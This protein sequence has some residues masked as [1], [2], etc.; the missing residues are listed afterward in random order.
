MAV[1]PESV[2]V[3][4][5]LRRSA[6]FVR[7]SGGSRYGGTRFLGR[8]G[9][10]HAACR[11]AALLAR[12]R[13]LTPE[14]RKREGSST[15]R[16]LLCGFVVCAVLAPP[17]YA[18][19]GSGGGGGGVSAPG[20]PRV[21]S[22]S[23]LA[24]PAGT[25]PGTKKLLRGRGFVVRGHGLATAKR[26]VFKGRRGRAD[27]VSIAPEQVT[28]RYATATV[29]QAARSG[30]V[31][32]LDRH[33]YFAAAPRRVAVSDAPAPTPVDLAPGSRF[34]FDGRRKPSF[35]FEVSSPVTAQV[36]LVNEASGAVVKTWEV[37]AA[38]GQPGTVSWDG[39][40]GGGVEDAGPYRFRLVGQAAAA[41]TGTPSGEAFFFAD[42]VFPI[43]GRHNLGYTRTNNF[44]GG[45]GHKGQDAFARCGTRVAAARGGRVQYAGYHSAAG[46]YAVIDGAETGIDYVYMHMLSPALVRTGQRVFTG[47]KIGEVGESGRATG[48]HLH[49]ELW[50]APGWYEGGQAFDPMPSLTLW[51]SYS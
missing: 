39:L 47:Q 36:E 27:D 32:V 13:Q 10:R 26:I 16:T 40:G 43:R 15:L 6:E 50:T 31:A 1:S 48:C 38:P 33:G 29:P 46:Y 41:T 49:F 2:L 11:S 5:T 23:C 37:P 18:E 20:A 25:C 9:R 44:G 28:G 7:R 4:P 12:V 19:D 21:D 24:T 35:S 30:G 3:S 34:F 14:A 8:I 42:H 22:V 17:V 45:R 51:D